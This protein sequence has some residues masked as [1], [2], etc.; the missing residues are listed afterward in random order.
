MP[1]YMSIRLRRSCFRGIA[2][3]GFMPMTATTSPFH[4]NIHARKAIY[5]VIL[6]DGKRNESRNTYPIGRFKVRLRAP[7]GRMNQRSYMP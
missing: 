4:S 1:S 7:A 2:Y 6:S 5:C 3:G